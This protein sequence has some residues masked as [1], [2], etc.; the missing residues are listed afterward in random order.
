M[1]QKQ[2]DEYVAKTKH[3]EEQAIGSMEQ[4]MRESWLKIAASYT[5]MAN[6]K[7]LGS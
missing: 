4:T 6:R 1:D 7:G 2:H 5:E 3:A